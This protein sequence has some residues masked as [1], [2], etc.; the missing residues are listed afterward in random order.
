MCFSFK[1]LIIYFI[2]FS[3]LGHLQDGFPEA[4]GVLL[5]MDAIWAATAAEKNL[6]G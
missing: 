1:P 3:P 5:D 6:K 4:L 2:L